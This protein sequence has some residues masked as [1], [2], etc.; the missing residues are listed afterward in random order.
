MEVIL[1]EEMTEEE[2]IEKKMVCRVNLR[3]QDPGNM[4]NPQCKREVTV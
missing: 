3:G 2:E 1:Q 4:E